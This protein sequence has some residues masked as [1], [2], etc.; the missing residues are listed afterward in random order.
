M[1]NAFWA[2]YGWTPCQPVS[3]TSEDLKALL[4]HR[5]ETASNQPLHKAE[6]SAVSQRERRSAW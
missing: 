3:V 5:V 4:E 1:L 6:K 2:R